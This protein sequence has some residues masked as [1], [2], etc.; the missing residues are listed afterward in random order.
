MGKHQQ[1][2]WTLYG[3]IGMIVFAGIGAFSFEFLLRFVL[4]DST[5][6]SPWVLISVFLG[7]LTFCVQL[8]L[9]VLD[10]R[11]QEGLNRDEKRRLEFI[12]NGKIRQIYAA[13]AFYL[14]SAS[15]VGALFTFM[16]FDINLFKYSV[17]ICGALL[18][19]SIF[20]TYLIFNE[21]NDLAK[22]KA[23]LKDRSTAAKNK[24]AAIERLSKKTND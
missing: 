5:L 12:I 9:K 3:A 2:G 21:I 4:N 18:G 13:I 19:M 1:A 17:I 7:P 24:A 6:A 11:E 14:V 22:F 15:I 10:L 8:F 16:T 20:S 23:K